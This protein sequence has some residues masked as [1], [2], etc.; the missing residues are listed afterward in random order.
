MR[1]PT[2]SQAALPAGV[3]SLDQPARATKLSH[4]LT[5]PVM[6]FGKKLRSISQSGCLRRESLS[7]TRVFFAQLHPTHPSWLSSLDLPTPKPFLIGINFLLLPTRY[8]WPRGTGSSKQL[9]KKTG[10]CGKSFRPLMYPL[11]SF[12]LNS[13]LMLQRRTRLF[14]VLVLSAGQHHSVVLFCSKIILQSKCWES[15]KNIL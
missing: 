11:S 14:F 10:R 1:H 13:C 7:K 12:T 2:S 5:M 9:C 3:F 15:Q 6:F 8:D 4:C